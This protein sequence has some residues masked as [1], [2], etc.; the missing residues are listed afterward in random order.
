M[1]K[2]RAYALNT[3]LLQRYSRAALDNAVE[4]LAEASL[5]EANGHQARAYFLAVASI[6]EMGKASLAFEAQG[7]NLS[8]PAVAAKLRK[9]FED[10]SSKIT[11]AFM[12]WLLA[13]TDVA[14]SVKN[15]IRLMVDLKFG[16]EPSMYVDVGEDGVSVHSPSFAVRTNAAS[17]C[18]RL[19]RD[20]LAHVQ[21]HIATRTPTKASAA[22]DRF[23]A[24]KGSV[25]RQM[26]NTEDFWEFH[27]DRLKAGHGELEVSV[28]TYHDTYFS[29][30]A[31]YKN[32]Q[33]TEP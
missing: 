26:M 27:I 5:L 25:T 28:T 6:E 14:S 33:R 9:S 13:C 4:L 7:R 11:A 1:Q 24:M 17:D 29:K 22:Q 16:R 32:N 2:V 3:A 10:H 31:T 15:A 12:P 18:V 21:R 30:R 8:D 20:C 23:F 19:A